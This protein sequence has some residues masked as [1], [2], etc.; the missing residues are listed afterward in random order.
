MV[1]YKLLEDFTSYPCTKDKEI[2]AY[3]MFVKYNSLCACLIFYGHYQ[4]QRRLCINNYHPVTGNN[5]NIHTVLFPM[6]NIHNI[7]LP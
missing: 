7:P 4:V 6:F 3:C 1:V 5:C 2:P